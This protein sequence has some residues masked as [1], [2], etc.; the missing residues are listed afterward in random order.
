MTIRELLTTTLSTGCE[1]ICTS[2]MSIMAQTTTLI[3]ITPKRKKLDQPHLPGL[4]TL[5]VFPLVGCQKGQDLKL[6]STEK[7]HVVHVAVVRKVI[8]TPNQ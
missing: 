1:L 2:M 8:F 5:P 4:V 6:R 3:T 7:L